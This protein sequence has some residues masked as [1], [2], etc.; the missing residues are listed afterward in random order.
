[1][2]I[3]MRKSAQSLHKDQRKGLD[4]RKVLVKIPYSHLPP[5]KVLRYLTFVLGL[6]CVLI[7]I[8]VDLYTAAMPFLQG[9]SIGISDFNFPFHFNNPHQLVRPHHFDRIRTE[10]PDDTL[11][12]FPF[13]T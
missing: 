8:S 2:R 5:A 13:H 7:L 9:C 1:M 12:I 4:H 6:A 10:S 11:P 3:I